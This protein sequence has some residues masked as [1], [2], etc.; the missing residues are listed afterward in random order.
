MIR[1]ECRFEQI[2]QLE[3]SW[4]TG[5]VSILPT[6]GSCL[7]VVQRAGRGFPERLLLRCEASG[8]R[9]SIMDGR[10]RLLGVGLHMQPTIL[11]IHVPRR[12]L[13]ELVVKCTGSRLRIES[14]QADQC[15]LHLRSTRAELSGYARRLNIRATGG[16]IEGERLDCEQL[17]L[18]AIS[19][20]TRLQGSFAELQL[21]CTGRGVLVGSDTAPRRMEITTTGGKVEVAIPD[22]DGFTIHA[23]K[24]PGKLHSDFPLEVP[25]REQGVSPSRGTGRVYKN[26]SRSYIMNVRGGQIR[27]VRKS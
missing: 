26:G 21:N 3:L 23:G 24:L 4:L 13:P 12:Q 22:N 18:Q 25:E 19:T 17:G 1:K 5:E 2:D 10:Q 6:E 8:S 20:S 14:S 11:E 27:L 16:Q 15:E 7:E 9:L